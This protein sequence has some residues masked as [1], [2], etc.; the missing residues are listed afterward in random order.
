MNNFY[1]L[2]KKRDIYF[3][4]IT[5]YSCA[6]QMQLQYMIFDAVHHPACSQVKA[7]R[8]FIYPLLITTPRL[9]LPYPL[10]NIR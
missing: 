4:I 6:I 5:V 1:D 2:L 10:V 3:D 9:V 7:I 8:Q